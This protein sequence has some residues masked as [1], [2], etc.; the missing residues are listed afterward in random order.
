MILFFESNSGAI[1]ATG[2][3]KLLQADEIA[4]LTWLFGN[5]S[6]TG[7]DI[8]EGNFIGPRKEMITPW[9]TNAVEITQNMG[10]KGI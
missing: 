6:L 4:K 1:I 2:T 3:D 5:A 8:I 10:L 9:S 7:N